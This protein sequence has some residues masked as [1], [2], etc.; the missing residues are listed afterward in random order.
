VSEVAGAVNALPQYFIL[1]DG[2]GNWRG[3]A[4]GERCGQ[5]ARKSHRALG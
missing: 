1:A 2:R 4:G 5:C 3:A